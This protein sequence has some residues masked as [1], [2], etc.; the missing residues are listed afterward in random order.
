M[1]NFAFGNRKRLERTWK[2]LSHTAQRISGLIDEKESSDN[3]TFQKLELLYVCQ[4][5][6]LKSWYSCAALRVDKEIRAHLKHLPRNRRLR[7][8]I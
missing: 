1:K 6:L 8:R 7:S 2:G 4:L 5:L 3:D